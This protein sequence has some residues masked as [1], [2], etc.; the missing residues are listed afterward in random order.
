MTDER[1][2]PDLYVPYD[3]AD[4]Y[5]AFKAGHLLWNVERA[6]ADD[7]DVDEDF[8]YLVTWLLKGG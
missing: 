3:V 6:E 1:E 4:L 2:C 7:P 5:A 8:H